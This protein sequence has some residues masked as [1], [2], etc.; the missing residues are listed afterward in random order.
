M[1][2]PV[3]LARTWRSDMPARPSAGSARDEAELCLGGDGVDDGGDGGALVVG[4][5]AEIGEAGVEHVVGGVQGP[6]GGDEVVDAGVEGLGDA[7]DG[8]EAGGDPAVFVAAGLAGAAADLLG[9]L[10][11]GQA[12]LGAAARGA[13]RGGTG[14]AC[15]GLRGRYVRPIALR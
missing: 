2:W 15:G 3:K 4:E 14:W 6:S 1:A 7:D 12:G 13:G 10:G 8:F 9:E 5:L 11:L